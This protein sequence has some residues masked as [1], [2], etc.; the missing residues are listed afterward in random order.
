MKPNTSDN[1]AMTDLADLIAVIESGQRPHGG[2][3]EDSGEIPSLGGENVRQGGGLDLSVLKKVPTD[4]YRAMTKGV[5]QAGDVLINKDGANTGKVGLYEGQFSVAAINEHLFLLRGNPEKL[6]QGFLYRLLNFENSQQEIRSRISGSAQP[7]LKSN[8][9]QRFPVFFPQSTKEQSRIAATLDVIDQ[10]IAVGEEVITKYRQIRSGLLQALFTCGLDDNGE[11]RNPVCSPNQFE[12]SPLGRI[13]I[14]WTIRTLE[15]VTDPLAPVCYGI[16]QALDHI[17]NGVP[18][19]AIRDMNG[20]Y[21]TGIHRTSPTIDA[22]YSRSRVRGGDVLLSIKGTI[23]RV[24]V[25]PNH[26]VGNISRDIARIRP[27]HSVV[28]SGFLCHMLRSPFGQKT[29]GLAQ[30]GTTRAELSI[31]PLKALKFAIPEVVE[32]HR[33]EVALDQQDV[34]LAQKEHELGKLK[35]LRSGIASALLTGRVRVP[36]E[37]EI[38]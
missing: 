34:V 15:D 17:S 30:V 6:D 5:L 7:G 24:S 4:F 12:S 31:G 16:V 28:R 13:P 33:I 11:L 3:T 23:G 1:W 22:M 9:I 10:V 8:F 25:V 14:S 36:A 37:L 35:Q 21:S 32:Q 19:L 38:A 27:N 2:A 20:D 26:Y 29:L 18:V